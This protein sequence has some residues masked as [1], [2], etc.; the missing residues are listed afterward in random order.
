M[1]TLSSLLLNSIARH[2]LRPALYCDGASLSYAEL[3]LRS[4]RLAA[5]L[6]S[7]GIGRG[8]AVGLH[9]RS[10]CEFV[11]ADVAILKLGAVKVPLNELM[12]P[13][14]L[15]YCISHSRVR[16]LIS[17]RSLASPASPA[18]AEAETL[19]LR[20]EVLDRGQPTPGAV[21]WQQALEH[22]A[23]AFE[24]NATAADDTAMIIYTG[25]TTGAPKGV[26]HLQG[27]LAINLFAHLVCGDIRPDEVMLLATPLSHAAGF[28][29]QACLLQGGLVVLAS[30]FEP[31]AFLDLATRHEAT[32]TFVVPTM[33]YRLLDALR[34][35]EKGPQS[36]RTIVYGAAPMASDRLRSALDRFGPVLLQIYG[37]TECPNFITVLSR[38]DHLQE[39]RLGSCGRPVPFVDVEIREGGTVCAPETVGELCVRSPYLLA[40]YFE[41]AQATGQAIVDGWLHTADLAYQDEEGYIFLVDRKKDMIISGGLN[42]YSVEVEAALRAHPD[43]A[44]VGVVGLP[45]EDWGERV[46]AVVV[47]RQPIDE[48]VLRAF[49]RE[50]LSGYKAPKQIVFTA[51]L[52]LTKYGKTD[53]VS[54]RAL[55]GGGGAGAA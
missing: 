50:R 49:A 18:G 4:S 39:G 19:Q 53:K 43:V 7:A 40:E 48:A 2:G 8:D 41:N 1:L 9:L 15:R 54:L 3:D 44:D 35:D 38:H 52:P 34:P 36:F 29:I 27:R 33:I 30:R 20:I 11:I 46:V 28:Q 6:R 47:A 37:Q 17:H 5:F 12:S 51:E 13:A 10:S 21:P 55:A 31:R 25:G 14:E 45:D 26:R 32:W 42:I 16:A 22:E 24:S 23:V